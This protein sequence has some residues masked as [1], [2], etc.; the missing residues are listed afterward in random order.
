MGK[1][2]IAGNGR[3]GQPRICGCASPEPHRSDAT[4]EPPRRRRASANRTLS[5]AGAR[6]ASGER[7]S[8]A[9]AAGVVRTVTFST[10]R[11]N[12]AGKLWFFQMS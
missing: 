7:R 11:V 1:K 10:R 12:A 5:L 2:E 8:S 4:A 3:A 9:R 6:G